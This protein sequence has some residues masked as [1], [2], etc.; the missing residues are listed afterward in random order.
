MTRDE[1]LL[2]LS[3]LDSFLDEGLISEVLEVVKGGKEAT[4][5]RCR[6][7]ES[8]GQRYFAA[9]VYRPRKYRSFRDDA[10]YQNGRVILSSR[11]RRAVKNRSD[12]GHQVHQK[13]WVAAE[14]DT[15]QT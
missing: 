3:L 10:A 15:Q 9:K 4:V 8:T 5:F 11:A 13:L 7:G 14:F 12:F 1:Q 2:L 6:A